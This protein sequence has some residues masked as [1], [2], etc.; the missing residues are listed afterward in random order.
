M[1]EQTRVNTLLTRDRT[2]AA[3]ANELKKMV[4]NAEKGRPSFD[5]IVRHLG[6]YQKSREQRV[7]AISIIANGLTRVHALNTWKDRLLAFRIL[8]FAGDMYV[9]K[10]SQTSI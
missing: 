5:N 7:A 9:H 8:P 3:L 2:A 10:L 6:N 4:G 1:L